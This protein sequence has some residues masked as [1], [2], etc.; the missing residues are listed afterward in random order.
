MPMICPGCNEPINEEGIATAVKRG[1]DYWH[2]RCECAT[3][4]EYGLIEKLF[5]MQDDFK[6]DPTT[7]M[8]DLIGNLGLFA[9]IR[10]GI[11]FKDAVR[12]GLKYWREERG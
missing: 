4:V 6:A 8:A 7:A 9:D 1:E 3:T 12:R 5:E 2:R 10:T 11:D